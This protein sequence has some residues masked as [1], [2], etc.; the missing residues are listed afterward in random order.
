[1]DL[2]QLPWV[3][4]R[5]NCTL[6]PGEI[7]TI[8]CWCWGERSLLQS[9][10]ICNGCPA[11]TFPSVGTLC[12]LCTSLLSY[13]K[14]QAGSGCLPTGCKPQS[15]KGVLVIILMP[16]LPPVGCAQTLLKTTHT[17]HPRCAGF[18]PW[19]YTIYN[20]LLPVGASRAAQDWWDALSRSVDSML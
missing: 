4:S 14:A 15:R 3:T 7:E 2:T 11:A 13:F 6:G 20:A 10:H 17:C 8:S 9:Q 16:R 19:R 12:C 5:T 18:S 1:M